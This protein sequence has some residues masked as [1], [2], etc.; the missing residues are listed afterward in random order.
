MKNIF[1]ISLLI[2]TVS[3]AQTD[4]TKYE[5]DWE[6]LLDSYQNNQ[7]NAA[8]SIDEIISNKMNINEASYP[9]IS[10]IPF[11]T[12]S[13]VR[14][15]WEAKNKYPKI[16]DIKEFVSHLQI[17]ELKKQLLIEIFTTT[18]SR[19]IPKFQSL[20][21]RSNVKFHSPETIA[22]QQNKYS[23]T[24]FS[25]YNKIKLNLNNK[26]SLTLITQ[27]DVNEKSFADF[28][29]LSLMTDKLYFERVILGNYQI[30]F[31][32]GLAQW[33]PYSFGKSTN[34]IV[35]VVKKPRG[36]L[37]NSYSEE[38]KYF[39]GLAISNQFG[40]INLSAFYSSNYRDATKYD[41]Y[42]SLY[43]SGYHRTENELMKKD[44]IR[45]NSYGGIIETHGN[46]YSVGF[47]YISNK[48]GARVQ[49][50]NN[51]DITQSNYLSLNYSFFDEHFNYTSEW[52]YFMPNKSVAT[53]HVLTFSPVAKWKFAVV[54]RNYPSN[55][56]SLN[57]QGFGEY[58]STQNERGYYFGVQTSNSFGRI[59]LY[60]DFFTRPS[61]TSNF[62]FP[63]NG[64]ELMFDFKSRSFH[65]LSIELKYLYEYKP[66]NSDDEIIKSV[67]L[68]RKNNYRFTLNYRKYNV[69]LRT[70][71]ELVKI[72]Y[73]DKT[74]QESGYYLYQEISFKLKSHFSFAFRATYF[75]TDSFLS[76]LY[77]YEKDIY[78]AFS[79]PVL[80][81]KGYKWYLLIKYT[82][83]RSTII[84][85]KIDEIYKPDEEQ[86]FS[87]DNMINSNNFMHLSLQIRLNL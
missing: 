65:G 87:S 77:S 54:Y 6:E 53:I 67:I 40:L 83:L 7:A 63:V 9:D 59:N 79:I 39:S 37:P 3:F 13:D 42:F 29:S 85:A 10:S 58:N 31:G 52:S 49:T 71:Y 2:S 8:E 38:N 4:T 25:N 30:Q 33:S 41:N 51:Q 60:Y 48:F 26:N 74:N 47:A 56:Y 44:L 24:N 36:I 50:A 46:N 16:E 69:Y 61:P 34:A 66:D 81:K 32:Q 20:N 17:E 35:P 84:E 18:S 45:L 57:S 27:K 21:L 62:T 80:Y 78:G 55:Y 5:I 64:N 1:L 73:N 86:L 70:R 14:Q 19:I 22:E 28:T 11:L 12:A 76:R 68:R 82:G 43:Y 15:I 23:G 75:N 72:S